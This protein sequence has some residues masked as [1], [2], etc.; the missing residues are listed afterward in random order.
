[1]NNII[2]PQNIEIEKAL[3]R[4]IIVVGNSAVDEIIHLLKTPE[5]FYKDEHQKLYKTIMDMHRKN[6]AIDFLTIADVNPSIS[7]YVIEMVTESAATSVSILT[8]AE[9][10]NILQQK[11]VKRKSIEIIHKALSK[12]N[13]PESY[14]AEAYYLI[15]K[16]Y[17]EMSDVLHGK[18]ELAD[19]Q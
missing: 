1:M 18:S 13:N 6:M 3:L 7:E 4:N 9:Y 15:E 2:A 5:L 19:M 17:Q 10:I 8:N 12:I 14:D 11:Y 16:A